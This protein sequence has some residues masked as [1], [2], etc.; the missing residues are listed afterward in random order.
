MLK[1]VCW[2][3]KPTKETFRY[4]EEYTAKHVN[5]FASMVS[6]NLKIP[7]EVVCITD[8][9]EGIN[10]NIR[11]VPLW[12]DLKEYGM[13]YRRLRSFSKNMKNIIGERFISMDLDCVILDDI[14][15]LVDN[16]NDFMMWKPR[17]EKTPYC[18]SMYMMNCGARSQIWNDFDVNNLVWLEDRNGWGEGKEGRWAHKK[19]Y[20]A[21]FVVGSDQ[22][23]ISYKLYPNEQVWT[24]KDGIYNFNQD[25]KKQQYLPKN[26]KIVFF[27][28]A[29]DP[30]HESL[31][32][33]NPWIPKYYY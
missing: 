27:P 25:I 6:R 16:N 26:V 14:T 3:W 12:H 17:E 13:C 32:K 1:V 21:G 24:K 8:N 20:K 7:H 30:S 11:I 4:R 15:S 9:S 23:W 10:S 19:A 31:Y 2:K 28:G 18:G 22:A 29:N 5:V 33:D